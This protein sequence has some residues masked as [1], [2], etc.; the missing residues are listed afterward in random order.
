MSLVVCFFCEV[1]KDQLPIANQ[2]NMYNCTPLI[3]KTRVFQRLD[4]GAMVF[5]TILNC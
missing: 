5:F 3:L 1:M 4:V 2:I